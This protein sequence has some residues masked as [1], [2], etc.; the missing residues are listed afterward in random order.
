MRRDLMDRWLAAL[1][2]GQ[3]KQG[4][5]RLR[6]DDRYCCLGV[7]CEVS[8]DG[9]WEEDADAS[10]AEIPGRA[11]AFADADPGVSYRPIGC[12]TAQFM[13]RHGLP[14][15]LTESLIRM[16][17]GGVPFSRIADHIEANTIVEE[18]AVASGA[19]EAS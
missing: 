1:R 16:N 17:D 10:T 15:E 6:T 5:K 11:Y 12:P 7:L 3:Y 4:R 18:D 9:T 19:G 13:T 8:G 2:G 14:S